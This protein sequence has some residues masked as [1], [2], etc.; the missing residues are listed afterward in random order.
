MK[1][2]I[3]FLLITAVLCLLFPPAQVITPSKIMMRLT[4][5]LYRGYSAYEE[6]NAEAGP[7]TVAFPA[8]A[9]GARLPKPYPRSC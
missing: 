2:R 1:K 3:A 5:I 8:S 7:F 9:G 6:E 4:K